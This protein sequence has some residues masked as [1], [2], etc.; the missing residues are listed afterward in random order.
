MQR[1]TI[2]QKRTRKNLAPFQRHRPPACSWG[3]VKVLVASLPHREQAPSAIVFGRPSLHMEPVFVHDVLLSLTLVLLQ[4]RLHRR[5]FAGK[6]PL[7]SSQEGPSCWRPALLLRSAHC[8]Q[9]VRFKA[10]R[11]R[12]P[13]IETQNVNTLSPF[14]RGGG[15]FQAWP[16]WPAVRSAQATPETNTRSMQSDLACSHRRRVPLPGC[17]RV[18]ACRRFAVGC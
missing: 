8:L 14:F 16:L 12:C 4:F 13:K 11:E 2:V 1:P 6:I 9:R 17:A 7:N 3:L 10:G 15:L 5:G 18:D